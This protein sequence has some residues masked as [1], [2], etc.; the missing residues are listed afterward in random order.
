MCVIKFAQNVA[1][2]IEDRQIKRFSAKKN[3]ASFENV[4]S[5]IQIDIVLFDYSFIA[6]CN[7]LQSNETIYLIYTVNVFKG[8]ILFV[9]TYPAVGLLVM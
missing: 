2:N 8:I 5:V 9:P 3:N 6:D 7:R 1:D 4:N